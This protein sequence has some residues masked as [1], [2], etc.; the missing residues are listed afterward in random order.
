M[1]RWVCDVF[2]VACS[3]TRNNRAGEAHYAPRDTL[4]TVARIAEIH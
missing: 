2:C 4:V 3:G 1:I